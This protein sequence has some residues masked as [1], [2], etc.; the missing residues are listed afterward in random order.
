[1]NRKRKKT[2]TGAGDS[3]RG[4][5]LVES[6]GEVMAHGCSLSLGEF[7]RRKRERMECMQI[8]LKCEWGG[9]HSLPFTGPSWRPFYRFS[10]TSISVL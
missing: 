4:R 7:L 10:V 3:K 5:E 8:R 9:S 2:H 1:M 6:K